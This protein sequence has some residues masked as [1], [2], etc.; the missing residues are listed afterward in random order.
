MIR[1]GSIVGVLLPETSIFISACGA[2]DLVEN[3]TKSC[4]HV[5]ECACNE[6]SW[7]W[8]SGRVRYSDV[9]VYGCVCVCERDQSMVIIFS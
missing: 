2:K 5:C 3:T 1:T 4:A 9:H 7:M 8:R 6:Q